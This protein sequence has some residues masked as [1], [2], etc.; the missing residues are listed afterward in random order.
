[1]IEKKLNIN[2][3]PSQEQDSQ[4]PSK[5]YLF[6]EVIKNQ[7][8]N[9]KHMRY[10]SLISKIQKEKENSGI[11]KSR[12]TTTTHVQKVYQNQKNKSVDLENQTDFFLSK[13]LLNNSKSPQET[14]MQNKALYGY[15][16]PNNYSNNQSS[17]HNQNSGIFII[18][19][20][21][22]YKKFFFKLY[23]L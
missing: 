4:E 15:F 9:N 23:L 14:K 12:M 11:T 13:N 10:K 7:P 3:R 16:F 5:S 8:D 1:M 2:K 22:T 21:K 19:Y 6:P 20:K 17:F 18:N